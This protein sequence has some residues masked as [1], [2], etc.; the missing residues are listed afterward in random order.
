MNW[1][2][3]IW[4][5]PTV[6]M[7]ALIIGILAGI[8]KLF[9]YAFPKAVR[10]VSIVSLML[11]GLYLALAIPIAGLVLV[12][13]YLAIL[14]LR[15][16]V[17]RLLLQNDEIMY[18]YMS[19]RYGIGYG[20]T[21]VECNIR[22]DGS[23]TVRREIKIEAVSKTDELDTFMSIPESAPPGEADREISIRSARSLTPGWEVVSRRSYGKKGALSI[24]VTISPP[25]GEGESVV[26][27]LVEELP[28]KLYAID[29]TETELMKRETPYDYFG[30]NINRPT[31]KL[32]MKVYFP[33]GIKPE[34]YGG[35]VRYASAAPG[36]PSERRQHEEEKR[37]KPFL[38]GPEG[39]RYFL[40]LDVDYPMIGLIYI[41]R[42]EPPI[43]K[44]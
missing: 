43:E 24:V 2:N 26:Y 21:Q 10:W 30:W 41:L 8:A 9:D 28:S 35:E 40:K 27:E 22:E 32:L 1:L 44:S 39:G 42:W 11:V 14:F 12:G 6:H 25:I 34:V 20:S 37:L 18:L 36:L 5:S 7:T 13:L 29:L 17:R 23:A 31:R 38:A 15:A 33:E 3:G 4:E 19:E 16:P